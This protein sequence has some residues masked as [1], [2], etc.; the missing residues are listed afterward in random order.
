VC[1][2][3]DLQTELLVDQ[4]TIRDLYLRLL[5]V[6]IGERLISGS[7]WLAIEKAVD[8]PRIQCVQ[9]RNTVGAGTTFEETA[10]ISALRPYNGSK[11]RNPA[12]N[13]SR[14]CLIKLKRAAGFGVRERPSAE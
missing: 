5:V 10:L 11:R 2:I 4:S 12:V 1:Q 9:C 3:I 7:P 8:A 13:I 14:E 6:A